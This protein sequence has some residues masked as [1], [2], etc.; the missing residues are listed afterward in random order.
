MIGTPTGFYCR[1]RKH[2]LAGRRTSRQCVE[3][4]FIN[5]SGLR[6]SWWIGYNDGVLKVQLFVTVTGDHSSIGNGN[7]RMADSIQ[8]FQRADRGQ[9]Q[10]P[11]TLRPQARPSQNSIVAPYRDTVIREL[12]RGGTH[13]TIHPSPTARVRGQR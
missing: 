10:P 12:Q 6:E 8:V 2:R 7:G 13:R 5:S 4:R 3:G 11:Q 9:D 1:P